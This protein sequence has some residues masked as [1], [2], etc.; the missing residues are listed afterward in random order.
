MDELNHSLAVDVAG[1]FPT[2]VERL[3]GRLYWGLRRISGSHQEAEDLAQETL[4]RAY[5]ALVD[6]PEE[7][8]IALRLD[9]WIWTIALNLGRNHIRDRA[10]R[11]RF[12]GLVDDV[13][14]DDPEPVDTG[15]WDARLSRLSAPQRTAV[16]LRH[17]VGM[18]IEEISEATG[19]PSGTVK[20]DIHRGLTRLRTI[21]E[22]EK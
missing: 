16:V 22:D 21:M 15:V 19:R 1:A 3:G 5:K 14:S 6:Y 12:V 20:A 9:P 10:R 18:G 17:V 2:V 8:V 13:A 4:I 7:R 11:P